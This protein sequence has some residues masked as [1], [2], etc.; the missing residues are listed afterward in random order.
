MDKNYWSLK[1]GE[2]AA[3]DKYP[4]LASFNIPIDNIQTCNSLLSE[5]AK[6]QV[7][8]KIAQPQSMVSMQKRYIAIP[9]GNSPRSCRHF[10]NRMCNWIK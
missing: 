7:K 1:E 6:L 10:S 2:K 3:P 5:L 8:L 4:I 9:E